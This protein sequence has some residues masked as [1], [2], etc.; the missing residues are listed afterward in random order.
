ME[1]RSPVVVGIG[2][3]LWDIFERRKT[4]GGAPA[5]F[6]YHATQAGADG[7]VVSAIGKDTLGDEILSVLAKKR[8][9][10]DLQ[11]VEQATGTVIISLD[12]D[13]I[14]N[15][16][17]PENTA[18]D[19]L[20]FSDS[21]R[22]LARKADAVCFGTLAQ[23]A[24]HS[25]ATI[26]A[27][28]EAMPQHALRIFDANLRQNFYSETLVRESLATA[29]IL[30]INEDELEILSDFFVG[31]H[32]STER[33]CFCAAVF[34]AFPQLRF[35]VLTC[36]ARGSYVFSR[37]GENS[38]VPAS[39]SAKIVDTVGAGDAFTATFAVAMLAGKPFAEAHRLAAQVA[40]FVCSR[41]GAM[42]ETDA[43]ALRL[44]SE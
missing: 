31:K 3:I 35:V 32:F 41:A 15:Y 14:A 2:E 38:F 8:L 33:N 27:F 34:A 44:F 10:T 37:S 5:N 12:G 17:F 24:P 43:S 23:R 39:P 26:R 16:A 20:K 40:E 7:I 11:R 18:W 9:H 1:K 25:R 22:A 21:L 29:N 6:A 4:L 30:K 42:P 28:L 36:G 19:N 13:G